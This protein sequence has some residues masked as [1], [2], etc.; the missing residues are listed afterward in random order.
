MDYSKVRLSSYFDDFATLN[1]ILESLVWG[2]PLFP[3]E[4]GWQI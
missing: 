1:T 2:A 4:K 3:K